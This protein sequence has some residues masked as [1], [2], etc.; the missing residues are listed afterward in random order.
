LKREEK[1]FLIPRVIEAWTH[2][3]KKL[4]EYTAIAGLLTILV[5][6]VYSPEHS[7]GPLILYWLSLVARITV[8]L[9]I[10][11]FH[12][13]VYATRRIYR[14]LFAILGTEILGL[15]LFLVLKPTIGPWSVGISAI[16]GLAVGT[17]LTYYYTKKTFNHLGYTK[18]IEELK[19]NPKP[20]YALPQIKKII[21][22][23]VPLT[24]FRLD[25]IV[26]LLLIFYYANSLNSLSVVNFGVGISLAAL[27][28]CVPI[29]QAAQEW[30]QLLYFDY[31]KLELKSHYWLKKR[32]ESG[33]KYVGIIVCLCLWLLTPLLTLA[34][35]NTWAWPSWQLLCLLLSTSICGQQA[36]RIF[37]LGSQ[38]ELLAWGVS[39]C[40]FLIGIYFLPKELPPVD[41]FLAISI[42]LLTHGVGMRLLSKD[43]AKTTDGYIKPPT[44]WLNS[45]KSLH[46]VHGGYIKIRDSEKTNKRKL[47][48]KGDPSPPTNYLKSQI[49]KELTKFS[50]HCLTIT[51]LSKTRILFFTK[52]KNNL[53]L[54][55]IELKITTEFNN[56]I[57]NFALIGL[58]TQSGLSP[59][60]P[61]EL[62]SH[63]S[64]IEPKLKVCLSTYKDPKDPKDP[65]D[66]Q[67]SDDSRDSRDSR[68]S[69]ESID[70]I[71]EQKY[72]KLFPEA[73]MIN[74]KKLKTPEMLSGEDAR[75]IL[76]AALR[77]HSTL[78]L[79]NDPFCK[80]YDVCCLNEGGSITTIFATPKS[81]PIKTIQSWKE[82]ITNKNITE[83]WKS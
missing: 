77:Y 29:L 33:L 53:K 50:K 45:L 57:E 79:K 39:L 21:A 83:A 49:T 69:N 24:L 64:K 15:V 10:R 2:L 17:F 81:Y 31:K 80:K 40:V 71:I 67:D 12:S 26:G 59:I 74:L 25:S 41:V 42:V 30:S 52:R 22:T 7:S 68:D 56:I 72:K 20:S 3:S 28:V 23:G 14:P 51:S 8:E 78:G 70:S 11:T 44:Q 54:E 62:I 43:K 32:F 5:V 61:N 76:S 19:K 1:S 38:K 18:A 35:D 9:P 6:S 48:Q 47:S 46:L 58:K 73:T 27:A 60:S 75:N 34:V 4:S 16:I 66:S 65:K 13:S 63:L 37:S 55:E 82:Y 36:I